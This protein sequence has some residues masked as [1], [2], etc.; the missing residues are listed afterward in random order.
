LSWQPQDLRNVALVGHR[1][2]GKTSL[3]EALLHTA[4]AIKALGSVD[5]GTAVADY[6]EQER[7]RKISISPVLCHLEHRDT[8][9]NLVDCP[10]YS[11]FYVDALYGLWATENAL[12]V[13]DAAA[14]VEVHTIK[15]YDAAR[16]MNV[17]AI[18]VV[19]KLDNALRQGVDGRG[20]GGA[21]ARRHGRPGGRGARAA[22]RR[23]RRHR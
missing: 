13:L 1:G 14:G 21:G 11:E 12:L 5:A 10:G 20:P 15:M 6:E 22:H 16:Q 7:E 9:V 8:K 4:G 17:R 19:N 3:N 18:G 2:V 23:G